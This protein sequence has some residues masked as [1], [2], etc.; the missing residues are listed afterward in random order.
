MHTIERGLPLPP[1]AKVGVYPFGEMEVGD[2]FLTA[3]A[4]RRV[5]AAASDYGKRHGRRFSVRQQA[6]GLRV[7]R[8]A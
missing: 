6:D 3:V 7:F 4:R 1:D 8:V 5:A 2:S